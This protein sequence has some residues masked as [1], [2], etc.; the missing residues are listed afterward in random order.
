MKW[1]ET[2]LG[3]KEVSHHLVRVFNRD[4]ARGIFISNS[5]YTPAA[6]EICKDS[7]RDKLTVLCKLKEFVLL[8][9]QEKDLYDFLKEK[10]NVAIAEKNPLYEPFNS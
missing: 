2:P 7:L 8:L 5:D 4:C 1:W 6:I 9:E 3:P 10:I